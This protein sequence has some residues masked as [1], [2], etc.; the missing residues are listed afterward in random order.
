MGNYEEVESLWLK[1]RQ[2]IK[3]SLD[4]PDPMYASAYAS[5]CKN[6]SVFYQL[7]GKVE[8]A[9]SQPGKAGIEYGKAANLLGE[10]AN[11]DMLDGIETL[12]YADDCNRLGSIS[13]DL[14]DYV[15]A[16]TYLV[17]AKM[18]RQK[19]LGVQHRRYGTACHNL[20]LLFWNVNQ[21]SQADN[22]FRESFSADV[23]DLNCIF[24]FVNEKEKKA[25]IKNV[26]GENEKTYSFYLSE[27]VQ[28][29]LPYDLSLFHRNLILSSLQNL[30]K[31][32][33]NSNDT[34]LHNK[35]IEWLDTK[36][37]LSA[38]YSLSLEKRKENLSDL[39][40]QVDELEKELT[41]L[42]SK[43]KKHQKKKTGK[44]F[45]IS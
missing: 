25:F 30:K 34:T 35:Y 7:K 10:A 14:N 26:L 2:I 15:T 16:K 27:R 41:R 17:K 40:R 11:I 12:K 1:A 36:A 44:R 22:E 39:E 42:S 32:I 45:R 13:M 4:R 20:A 37:H 43:F 18:I 21:L 24:D 38:I 23:F 8:M 9:K 19:I 28:S 31:Q 5:V 33:F 3:E 29:G 6:L